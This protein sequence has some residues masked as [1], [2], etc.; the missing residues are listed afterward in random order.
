MCLHHNSRTCCYAVTL[1]DFVSIPGNRMVDHSG[2]YVHVTVLA[3]GTVLI[4]VG[5]ARAGLLTDSSEVS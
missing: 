2:I 5:S 4:Y 1:A 3:D